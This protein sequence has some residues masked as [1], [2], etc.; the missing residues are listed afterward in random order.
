M[1]IIDRLQTVKLKEIINQIDPN[2]FVIVADV[3][4]VMGEGFSLE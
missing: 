4:E 3:R 1:C 2:A